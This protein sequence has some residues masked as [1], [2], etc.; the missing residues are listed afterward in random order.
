MKCILCDPLPA[1][2]PLPIGTEGYRPVYIPGDTAK[3][4]GEVASTNTNRNIET[5]G[6]LAGKLVS[7]TESSTH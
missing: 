7:S 1:F 2:D 6:I 5:C 3:R 4:F